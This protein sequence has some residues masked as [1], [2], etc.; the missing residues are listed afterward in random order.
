MTGYTST[1]YIISVE[2]VFALIIQNTSLSCHHGYRK[3]KKKKF[4][5]LY[6]LTIK[7]IPSCEIWNNDKNPFLKKEVGSSGRNSKLINMH[8]VKIGMVHTTLCDIYRPV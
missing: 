5:V 4:E 1:G 2:N 3:K 8:F 7:A 6:T